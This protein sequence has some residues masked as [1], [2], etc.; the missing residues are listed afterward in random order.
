MYSSD[1]TDK[2]GNYRWVIC[3]LLFFATTINYVDRQIIGLLKPLLEKEFNWSETHYSYIVSAFA[4]SYAIGYFI[5]GNLIDKVGS[6]IGYTISIVFWSIAAMAHAFVKS[7]MGFGIT[8]AFLGLGEGG[9]FPAAVKAVAEWFPKKERA[10]AT[11]IFNSGTSIGA[12]AAPLIVYWM[13]GSFGWR[14]TFIITGAL[15]F[16]WLLPWLWFYEIPSRQTRVSRAELAYI[17]GDD[18]NDGPTPEK[19]PIRKLLGAKDAWVFI[20]GK[21]L[22]DPVWWFFLFWLPSY[23][24]SNFN[25]DLKTPGLQV[26]IVYAATTF[27]SIGGGYWSSWLIKRGLTPVMARKYALLTFALLVTPILFV[28]LA[29]DI[30]TVVAIISLAAAAH[31]GWSANLFT[32]VSDIVPKNSVSSVVGIGGMMGS[33]GST[34]FPFLVGFILDHYKLTGNLGTGYNLI[35]IICGSAYLI[36]WLFIHLLTRKL[37]PS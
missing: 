30:S 10:L 33:A 16:I 14:A 1:A 29:T 5:F 25:L 18:D 2:I 37:R 31:Q 19:L 34:L 35:F 7:T 12:V 13:A 20:T 21:F 9:N 26:A 28:R 22:T 23:F 36:A 6:K 32:I 4:A 27:G 17:H 3:A 24:S 15:G 8:R 11:G